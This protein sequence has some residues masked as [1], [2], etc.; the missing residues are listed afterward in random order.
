VHSRLGDLKKR[1]REKQPNLTIGVVGCMAERLKSELLEEKGGVDLVVGPDAYRTLPQLLQVVE[2]SSNRQAINTMLSADETY[3]D[4]SPVRVSQDKVSAFVSI[5][6]GCNNMCAFCIVPHVRGVERSR[7]FESILKEVQELS[8]SGYKEVV[9][10]GQNVNTYND[11]SASSSSSS[12]DSK[13]FPLTP[14][15]DSM[16][17]MPPGGRDFCSLIEEVAKID[18]EM[19]VRF[20]S[21][22]PKAFPRRLLEIV[23]R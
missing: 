8:D 3:A 9:L 2:G 19:R 6:R 7:P 15:F 22:H 20:T 5:A 21:P 16:W 13:N 14:G 11:L 1:K 10:L 12:G 17:K 4:I 23:A 18:P